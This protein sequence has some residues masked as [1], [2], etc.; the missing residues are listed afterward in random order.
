MSDNPIQR[1]S[2]Q[3]TRL[4]NRETGLLVTEILSKGMVPE[5]K[6]YTFNGDVTVMA[7][8]QDYAD[9]VVRIDSKGVRVQVRRR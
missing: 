2:E 6:C 7:D 9:V 5:L 1:L 3:V 8:S 4:V